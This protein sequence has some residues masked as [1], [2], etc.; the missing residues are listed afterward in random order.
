MLF[1]ENQD[2]FIFSKNLKLRKNDTLPVTDTWREFQIIEPGQRIE[3]WR[4]TF[5][6]EKKSFNI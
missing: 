5:V 1:D 4:F 3:N 6:K 2:Y